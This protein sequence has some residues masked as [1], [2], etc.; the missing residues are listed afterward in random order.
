MVARTAQRDA[1]CLPALCFLVPAPCSGASTP[2]AFA[3]RRAPRVELGTFRVLVEEGQRAGR[4]LPLM[5]PTAC[6]C[7]LPSSTAPSSSS[8]PRPSSTC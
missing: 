3:S 4:A 6:R 5:P 2:A 1:L 7:R 8:R